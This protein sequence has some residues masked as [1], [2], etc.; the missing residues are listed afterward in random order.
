MVI[1]FETNEERINQLKEY[2]LVFS[3]ELVLSSMKLDSLKTRQVPE[4]KLM[5]MEMNITAVSTYLQS[6]CPLSL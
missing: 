6:K 2:S 5:R 3:L 1:S 4:K